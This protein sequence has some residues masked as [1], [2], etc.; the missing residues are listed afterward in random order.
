MI[1]YVLINAAFM[2]VLPLSELAESPLAAADA[3]K[4]V[5]G[6]NG[7]IVVSTPQVKK[8]SVLVYISHLKLSSSITVQ[9]G[10]AQVPD[11]A[12]RSTLLCLILDKVAANPKIIYIFLFNM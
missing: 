8:V 9:Y 6:S 10:S 1:I 12:L 5:F 7:S 2:Y 4:A 11:R 3:A